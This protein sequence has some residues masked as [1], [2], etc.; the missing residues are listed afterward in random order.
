MRKSYPG[1]VG[2]S[3]TYNLRNRDDIVIPLC[4]L[5]SYRPSFFPS[6]IELWNNLPI[7]MRNVDSLNLLKRSISTNR[8]RVPKFYYS[9][10]GKYT[11][12]QSRLRNECSSLNADLFR[13]NIVNDPS[14][15][16]GYASE[17]SFHYF[18]ECSKYLVP[19]SHV[20]FIT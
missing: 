8:E 13:L 6:G 19:R 1:S 14:Y 10:E 5:E 9:G 12:Y 2:Q 17:N 15:S 4:R 18:F 3:V 20:L 16:C 11:I 7:E